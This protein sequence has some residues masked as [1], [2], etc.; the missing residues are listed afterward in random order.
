MEKF[1]LT[2]FNLEIGDDVFSVTVQGTY[3]PG[4][5]AVM[6][7]E[8]P[9]PAEDAE[10]YEYTTIDTETDKVLDIENMGLKPHQIRSIEDD[11]LI[12]MS[13]QEI[14]ENLEFLKYE[15]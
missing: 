4:R 15:D 8:C 12:E 1:Y 7:G 6:F 14:G 10:L 2:D 13:N 9:E 5:D 11:I 3:Y